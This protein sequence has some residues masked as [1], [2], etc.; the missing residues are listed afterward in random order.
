MKPTTGT[1]RPPAF[2]TPLRVGTPNIG[3][4]ERF[5]A[6][7]N[8]ALDRGWLSNGGPLMREFE[9]RIAEQ[10]G[11]RHAV[12]TCNATAALQLALRAAGLTGEVI[13][14]ALTF[15][16]TA[17]AVAWIGLTPVFCDVDPDTGQLD[18]AHA[19]SLIGPATSGILAVHLWGRTAPVEQLEKL[20]AAHGLALFFDASHAYACTH[21]G[22]PVGRAG[23]GEIFSFHST[24]FVNAF[25]G[26]ALVT[27]DDALAERALRM[28]NFGI[29]GEDLVE[30]VGINAK[31]SE[32]AAAM[33]LTSLDSLDRFVARNLANLRAYER[34][35]AGVPGLRLLPFPE[36]ERHNY[37][38]VILEVDETVAGTGRDELLAV[39]RSENVLARKYFHP[40]CHQ[41]TPYRG[42]ARLPHAERLAARVLALPT[43]TQVGEAGISEICR[44]VRAAV[45]AC[46]AE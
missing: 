8:G 24:K 10:S 23:N 28:R 4:R 34:G 21:A 19:E 31:M 27:D 36:G 22:Q 17:H 9:Q 20:A 7:L 40:A 14:P 37:Q 45:P 18:P 33:G 15:A 38:Y 32:A 1:G 30:D 11:T 6:R 26:G 41:M 2:A 5:W 39:L 42:P 25:E 16:A 43:G 12:A 3:D 44:I 13:V 46:T 29:A 35:L